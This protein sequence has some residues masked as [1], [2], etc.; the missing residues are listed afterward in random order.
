[1]HRRWKLWGGSQEALP[2]IS[3][4]FLWSSRLTPRSRGST[5]SPEN[6]L[7]NNLDQVQKAA[8][9][10]AALTQQLLAFS[11]KQVLLPRIIDLNAVVEDSLKMIRRLIGEDIELNVSP[12]KAL[13]AV[14]AD[15]GQIVQVLMNLCVNARDAMPHG[16]ELEFQTENVSL[17]VEAAKKS[18]PLFP[19]I[20]L[21]WL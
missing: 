13:W 4:I 3:T 1:M 5:T 16:G 21:L 9:R 10:A 11:R 2:M 19:A 18:L 20:T 6:V 14:K 15:P 12:G 17:D 7:Q 8:E